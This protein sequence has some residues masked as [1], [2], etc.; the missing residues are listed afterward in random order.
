MAK[1][2][3]KGLEEYER[4]LMKLKSLSR[5]CIGQ[6]IHDGA[7]VVADQVRANIE[8]LPIDERHVKNGEMLHGISQA[9]KNGLLDGFGISRMKDEGGYINVKLGFDGY[10]SVVTKSF[11]QGQPNSMIARSVNS[12]ASFRQRIPFVDNAV[13]AKKSEC[14]EKMAKKF[15][16]VL[17]DAL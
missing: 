9:Q 7:A 4:Q 6:A 14:E 2:K 11:P 15:D 10:N 12:G 1:L 3:M 5:E 8:A 13:K 17:N 16:E